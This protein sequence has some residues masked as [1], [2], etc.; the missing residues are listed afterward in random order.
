VSADAVKPY[1]RVIHVMWKTSEVPSRWT[2]SSNSWL[3]MNPEF[4]YC[5]WN[6]TELESFVADEYP[7]LLSTYRA[8]P[9]PIQRADVAR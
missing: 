9:Y 5:H 4:V 3:N 6:D 2:R 7:W 8:Y 1:T